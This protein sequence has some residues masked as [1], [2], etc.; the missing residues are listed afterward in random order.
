M[1]FTLLFFADGNTWGETW[2]IFAVMTDYLIA[3]SMHSVTVFS[4]PHDLFSKST[5]PSHSLS[6][7][8]TVHYHHVFLLN[9]N[10]NVS[11]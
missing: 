7:I 6:L 2:A 10:I 9:V 3:V 8:P 11:S 1:A 5:A 4:G